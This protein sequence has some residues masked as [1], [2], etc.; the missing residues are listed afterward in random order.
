MTMDSATEN[1]VL[2][3]KDVSEDHSL[4][5]ELPIERGELQYLNN[6]DIA[7]Y[8]S[9]FVDHPDPGNKRH[10]VRSWHR[11]CGEITYDG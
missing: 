4:W 6:I 10:L 5:F 2:A 7:H 11:N 3:L 1:A 9:E 8:R